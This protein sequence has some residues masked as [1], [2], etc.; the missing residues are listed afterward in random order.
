MA[1]YRFPKEER[2]CAKRDIELLFEKSKAVRSGVLNIRYTLRD[3]AED[4]EVKVLI[5][6]P[7]KRVRKAI[8]RN[9]VKRQLR[10]IYRLNKIDWSS[11]GLPSGNTLLLA[12]HYFG[13]PES[14]YSELEKQYL[15]VQKLLKAALSKEWINKN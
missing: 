10:E 6:V 3:R 14:A 15:H 2:V 12:I 4:P 1:G 9:R 8:Q 11:L 5:I 13:Q 7:K